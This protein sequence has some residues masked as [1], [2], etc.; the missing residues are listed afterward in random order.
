M[1]NPLLDIKNLR[2]TFTD[3]NNHVEALKGVSYQVNKGEVVCLVGES[4]SGKSV[5]AMAAMGLLPDNTDVQA[6]KISFDGHDLLTID[7]EGFRKLRGSQMSMIFQEPMTSLNPVFKVGHQVEEVLEIHTKLNAKERKARVLEL[8][9]TVELDSPERRY[10]AYP[11]QLSGGQRQRVMIAM[12]LATE[13]KLLIADEPTTALDV[14]VQ[15]KI[16]DL[17]RDLIKRFDMAVLFITHDFG[18]VE[19]LGDRVLV[20][21]KGHVVEEGAVKTVM[22]KPQHAYTKK[23]LAAM[24]RFNPKDATTDD[25]QPLLEVNH[26]EK[27]FH[28]RKGGLFSK[29]EAFRAVDDVSFKLYKGETLGVVGES[30]CGKSTLARCLIGLYSPDRGNVVF[31]GQ[32]VASLKGRGLKKMRRNMQMVFQDP[33]SSLNPRMRI[34]ESVGEG[35]RAHG[36]MDAREREVFVRQLLEDC[37]L[38]ANSYDRFPHQ[39]SGGQRQRICIARALSLK[40]DLIIADEAVSALDVSVQKQILNLLADLKDKYN[41]SYLFISHDLRVVSELCDRVLVMQHGKVVEQGRTAD[42]FGHPGHKYTQHLLASIPGV[43]S[44]APN[45]LHPQGK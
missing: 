34:G 24:P 19:T 21:E 1:P 33:F 42:V 38:P 25:T 8:F 39:F 16:L 41:L 20:M 22:K 30:G 29:A 45:T 26:L 18:V 13:T 14:T 23:L 12:A 40:P 31:N 28:V 5:S 10:H 7:P 6:D 35:L 27:H 44:S 17:L 3:E 37:G 4:G 2:V 9:R 32:D 43:A 36:L 15:G 11:N